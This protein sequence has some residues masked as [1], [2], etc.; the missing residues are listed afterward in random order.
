[1]INILCRLVQ[2]CALVTAIDAAYEAYHLWEVNPDAVIGYTSALVWSLLTIAWV[3][4]ARDR[5]V[6]S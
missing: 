5:G 1:M 2:V 4:L 6:R 3:K